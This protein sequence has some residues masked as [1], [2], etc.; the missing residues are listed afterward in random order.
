MPT[1]CFILYKKS[2]C[3]KVI[4]SQIH[5]RQHCAERTKTCTWM[6][7]S[8]KRNWIGKCTFTNKRMEFLLIKCLIWEIEIENET[9]KCDRNQKKPALLVFTVLCCVAFKAQI[10]V[11]IDAVDEWEPKSKSTIN[12]FPHYIFPFLSMALFSY[13]QPLKYRC[14]WRLTVNWRFL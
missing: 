6:H 14:G 8:M 1:I 7:V 10:F 2:L 5:F 13:H 4:Y 11:Y 3:C 12:F 9:Y